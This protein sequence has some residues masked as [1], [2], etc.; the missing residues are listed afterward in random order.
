MS[1][2]E[3]TQTKTSDRASL[4]SDAM[5]YEVTREL[6]LFERISRQQRVSASSLIGKLLEL[7]E[8]PYCK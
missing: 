8:I 5:P 4:C 2:A 6:H 3:L 1:L 7:I